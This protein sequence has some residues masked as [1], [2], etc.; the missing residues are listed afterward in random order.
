MDKIEITPAEKQVIEKQLKGDLNPFF[1][2]DTE[3]ELID[4]VID[5][6]SALMAELDAYDELDGDLVKWYYDK[7]KAQEN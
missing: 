3:R 1:I 6:A 7:Y 4:G 2:N 5:K